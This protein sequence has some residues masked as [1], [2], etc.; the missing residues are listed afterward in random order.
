MKY[1]QE[2][3][4]KY[5]FKPNKWFNILPTISAGRTAFYFHTPEPEPEPEP[6]K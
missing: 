1:F 6:S 4:N 5:I 2:G 3:Q